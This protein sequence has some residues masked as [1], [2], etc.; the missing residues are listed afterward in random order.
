MS[1]PRRRAAQLITGRPV[2]RA[3]STCQRRHKRARRAIRMQIR[4]RAAPLAQSIVRSDESFARLESGAA[5]H[6]NRINLAAAESISGPNSKT[7]KLSDN[8]FSS[9]A[10]VD[11][12]GWDR[13]CISIGQTFGRAPLSDAMGGRQPESVSMAQLAELSPGRVAKTNS[14]NI[15][16]SNSEKSISNQR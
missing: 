16:S 4:Q 13:I 15:A 6:S 5:A 9:R 8:F 2:R 3:A 11:T 12:L 10:R 1:T 7:C 14:S